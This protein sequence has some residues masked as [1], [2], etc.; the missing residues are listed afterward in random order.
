MSELAGFSTVYVIS[1]HTFLKISFH[2]FIQH[3]FIEHS[4]HIRR[5]SKCWGCNSEQNRQPHLKLYSL[6]GARLLFSV[7]WCQ[8]HANGHSAHSLCFK[9]EKDSASADPYLCLS[10]FIAPLHSGVPDYLGLFAV[11]CFGV[12][13]LSKAYEEECDDYSSIMVKALGDRLAEVEP[14]CPE[15]RVRV[16]V[17]MCVCVCLALT[18]H[19]LLN[20]VFSSHSH[21]SSLGTE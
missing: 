11:A 9:A 14:R 17:C 19:I 18:A 1:C 2:L 7:C 20:P 21:A 15:A 3:M 4:L 16:H 13:E 5:S 12:E 6:E 10:D 8:F